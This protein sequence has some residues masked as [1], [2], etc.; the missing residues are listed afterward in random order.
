ME[1][2]TTSDGN[3]YAKYSNFS[4]TNEATNYTLFVGFYSGSATDKL[5]YFNGMSFSTMDRDNDKN[6][7]NCSKSYKGAWWYNTC[8]GNILNAHYA[9]SY[10]GW[11]WNL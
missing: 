8:G 6:G 9:G 5:K 4:I 11:N 1:I 7:G 2:N 3:K 10:Y